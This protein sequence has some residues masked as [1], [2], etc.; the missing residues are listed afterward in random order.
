MS[1]YSITRGEA[2][3]YT[4]AKAQARTNARELFM[5]LLHPPT[6]RPTAGVRRFIPGEALAFMPDWDLNT[7]QEALRELQAARLVEY[8]PGPCLVFVPLALELQDYNS[9]TQITGAAGVLLNHPPSPVLARPLA[10]LAAA[11]REVGRDARQKAAELRDKGKQ[12]SRQR[13]AEQMEERAEALEARANHARGMGSGYP[14]DTPSIG[15]GGGID[16]VSGAAGPEGQG[17]EVAGES[18]GVPIGPLG[19][20]DTLSIGPSRVGGRA[21]PRA[22]PEPETEPKPEPVPSGREP[23]PYPPAARGGPPKPLGQVLDKARGK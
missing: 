16:R 8:D 20:I 9:H 10:A 2:I 7:A 1:G 15:C 5:F 6:E 18:P 22:Q 21:G 3:W 19:G 17:G 23:P 11:A 13:Q 14:Q 4:L 12:A